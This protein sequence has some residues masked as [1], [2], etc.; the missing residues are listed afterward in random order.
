VNALSGPVE[1]SLPG[2]PALPLLEAA[3]SEEPGAVRTTSTRPVRERADAARNRRKVLA[4]AQALFAE[5]GVAVVTMDDVAAAAGVGKG[6][7]Y[8]R[9]GDKSGLAAALLDERE[10]DL[11][12]RMLS[13]PPP[14][15]PDPLPHEAGVRVTSG[16]GGGTPPSERLAAF[17]RAYL[18]MLD[19]VLLSETSTPGA[20]HRTG[21]HAFWATH[22]RLLL[23]AAGAPDAALRADVLLA[24]LAADQV[25]HWRERGVG[26][27]ELAESLG[28]LAQDLAAPPS[29]RPSTSR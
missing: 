14:L 2:W 22:C 3:G 13:G 18:A 24:A 7:L 12:S 17:V 29:A 23:Q 9:F 19:I 6:T 27:D 10:R 4:A 15:G 20:R 8:R 28:R 25:R 21:A 1:S 11:Q 5:R 26:L 16:S